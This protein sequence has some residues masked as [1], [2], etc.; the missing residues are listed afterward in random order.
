MMFEIGKVNKLKVKRKT[1]IGY[2]LI[3]ENEEEIFLHNNDSNFMKLEPSMN[4]DAFVFYDN[5]KRIAATLYKPNLQVGQKG[6]L[7]VQGVNYEIGVFLDL[8]ISK[9]LLLSKDYLP[10]DQTLWPRENDKLY[11]EMFLGK[12]LLARLATPNVS[13]HNSLKVNDK[14]IGHVIRVGEKGL[15]ILTNNFEKVFIS[16][17][18]LRKKIRLGEKLEFIIT[19]INDRGYNAKLVNQSQL[20][21]IEEDAKVILDYLKQNIM[22]SLD[23]DSSPEMIKN[24]FN[25]SKK[26]F[27]KALGNLYKQRLVEFRDGK[28]FYTKFKVGEKNGK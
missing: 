24:Y 9:G 13:V 18:I 7:S 19:N 2:M 8:G 3:N 5:K 14:E 10:Y 1:D 21:I 25:M 23:S 11:V 26:A 28:T 6:F 16:S 17:T 27:K 4:V 15:N 20:D 22:L 12:S